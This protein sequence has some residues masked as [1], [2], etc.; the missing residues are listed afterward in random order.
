FGGIV[1]DV[2]GNR[3]IDLGSGIAV[4]TIGNASPRV[5]DAVAEQAAKFTHT[6]FMVTPYEGYVAVAEALNRLTPGDGDKR[7][8]LFNSGSEAV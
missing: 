7:T 3:L 6:C 1:E 8:A 4:T 2:D 5:V